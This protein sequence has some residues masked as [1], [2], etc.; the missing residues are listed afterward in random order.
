M[1][2][3]LLSVFFIILLSACKQKPAVAQ[4]PYFEGFVESDISYYPDAAA[5][6]KMLEQYGGTKAVT[7]IKNGFSTRVYYNQNNI[8]LRR[9]IY[10]R[11][12]LKLYFYT[13][14][15][16]TISYIDVTNGSTVKI[17]SFKQ[18]PPKV[19][20]HHY[21]KGIALNMQVYTPYRDA[22]VN[23][24]YEYYFDTSNH[25]SPDMYEG[26]KYGNY[27]ELFR[28]YPY[29]NLQIKDVS[30]LMHTTIIM[31]ATRI[32]KTKL[33]NTVFTLPNNKIFVS[34]Y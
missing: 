26:N 28:L 15:T 19:I 10:N 9:E 21:C 16:D 20:L 6:L 2:F 34:T 11:D 30:A 23:E 31:T 32:V 12:S 8:I 5:N 24:G 33:D 13:G 18:L 17:T 29:I 25:L 14:N 4:S 1:K 27:D 7:Y 22:P 3:I